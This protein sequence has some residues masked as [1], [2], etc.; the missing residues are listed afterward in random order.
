MLT[1]VIVVV[2][3]YAALQ[4]W[5]IHIAYNPG[6]D[7]PASLESHITTQPVRNGKPTKVEKPF[8]AT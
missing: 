6:T 8:G 7:A 3:G 1:A 5:R 2:L 4:E